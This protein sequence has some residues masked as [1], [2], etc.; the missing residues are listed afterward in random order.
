[1][2]IDG[3]L[4]RQLKENEPEVFESLGRPGSI[5]TIGKYKYF[6]SF[7]L[8]SGYKEYELSQATLR[9]CRVNQLVLLSLHALVFF[10]LAL[11]VSNEA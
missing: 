6:Y 7:I 10:C 8:F 2:A 11:I 4:R 5:N 9:L 1:M 3:K